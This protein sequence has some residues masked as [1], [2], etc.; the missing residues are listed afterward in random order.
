[1]VNKQFIAS[2]TGEKKNAAKKKARGKLRQSEVFCPLTDH[3]TVVRHVVPSAFVLELTWSGHG[4]R[5]CLRR[6]P[7]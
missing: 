4:L 5:S 7:H 1:M 3:A 6:L 2:E